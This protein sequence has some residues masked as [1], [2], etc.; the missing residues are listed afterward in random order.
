[1]HLSQKTIKLLIIKKG[2][3]FEKTFLLI[4]IMLIMSFVI[5]FFKENKANGFGVLS[6]N[7][8]ELMYQGEFLNDKKHGIGFDYLDSSISYRGEFKHDERCGMGSMIYSENAFYLGEWKHG[9]HNGFVKL[10]K[11]QLN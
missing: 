4:L 10:T 5:G 1:M 11:I 6:K 3:L 9:L 2:F 7:Q 8:D